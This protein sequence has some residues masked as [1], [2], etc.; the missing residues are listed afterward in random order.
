VALPKLTN[1]YLDQ[2]LQQP[3]LKGKECAIVNEND[4]KEIEQDKQ[5]LLKGKECEIMKE[6]D[7]KETE[8]DKRRRL[9]GK[10]FHYY[11]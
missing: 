5:R 3:L 7:D 9:K 8:Q 1:L 11:E 2:Y 4:D 10:E 6:N